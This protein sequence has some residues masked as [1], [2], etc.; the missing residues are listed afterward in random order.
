MK[1]GWVRPHCT[2]VLARYRLP[3]LHNA[4]KPSKRNCLGL[5]PET[6]VFVACGCKLDCSRWQARPTGVCMKSSHT[7]YS[8]SILLNLPQCPPPLPDWVKWVFAYFSLTERLPNLPNRQM[9]GSQAG[10][11]SMQ[12]TRRCRLRRRLAFDHRLL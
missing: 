4:L 2:A 12:T 1:P 6:N 8:C 5:T 11:W 7:L 9:T 10:Q 3:W